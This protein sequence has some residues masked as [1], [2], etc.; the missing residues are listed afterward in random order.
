[1]RHGLILFSECKVVLVGEDQGPPR[2]F[3][4]G[5]EGRI[6]SWNLTD[7]TLLSLVLIVLNGVDVRALGGEKLL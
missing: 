4:V 3:P 7:C 6:I 1:M 5:V 2:R